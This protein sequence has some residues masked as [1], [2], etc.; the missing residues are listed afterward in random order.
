MNVVA[1][2]SGDMQRAAGKLSTMSDILVVEDNDVSLKYISNL[3]QRAGFSFS[4]STNGADA[5]EQLDRGNFKLVLMDMIMP[6]MN[7]FDA[8][9]CIRKNP[10][11][12]T[13][14]VVALTSMANEDARCLSV[15]CNAVIVKPFSKDRVLDMIGRMLPKKEASKTRKSAALASASRS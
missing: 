14:P 1:Q 9:A 2:N 11:F 4:V 3:L 13:L 10:R 7:G 8:T 15:G 6:I 12:K 5:V